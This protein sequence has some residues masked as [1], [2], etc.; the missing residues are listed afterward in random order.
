MARVSSA[1]AARHSH[2]AVSP[3]DRAVEPSAGHLP[4]ALDGGARDPE[5]VRGIGDRKAGE[6]AAF[7]D[8]GEAFVFVL[9]ASQCVVERDQHV[10]VVI[11]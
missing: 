11:R 9:E 10:E 5:H 1:S 3:S 6:E 4:V 8:P 7:D 2:S